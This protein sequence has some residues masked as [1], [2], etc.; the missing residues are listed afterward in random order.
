LNRIEDDVQTKARALPFI[1]VGTFAVLLVAGIALSVV[2]APSIDEQLLQNA[3]NAT[4]SASG[5]AVTDTNSA[6]PVSPGPSLQRPS[7]PAAQTVV[8]R[9]LYQAPDAVEESEAVPAGTTSVILIGNRR[10]QGI[11]MQWTELPDSNGAAAG[12]IQRIMFPLR[13]ASSA[14]TVTRHGD[15]YSFVPSGRGSFLQSV[16]GLPPSA[17]SSPILTAVV[18]GGYL[19][20][21]Q[22]SAVADHERLRVDLVFSDIGSASPVKEPS[23]TPVPTPPSGTSSAP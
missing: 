9:V 14:T 8:I 23:I 7:S 20:E 12:A 5:F 19:D 3:A 1:L 4:M 17:L 15:R 6:T 21:E 11:G 13:A 22:I 2:R 10:F 18:R 16:L